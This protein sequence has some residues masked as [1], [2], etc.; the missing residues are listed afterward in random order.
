MI[1]LSVPPLVW[2]AGSGDAE[3]DRRTRRQHRSVNS[4]LFMGPPFKSLG[5][6]DAPPVTVAKWFRAT[7]DGD[8]NHRDR[9]IWPERCM[10]PMRRTGTSFKSSDEY[11]CASRH[12]ALK[13]PVLSA[14]ATSE[15]GPQAA[16]TLCR[17]FADVNAARR[18]DGGDI[19]VREHEHAAR[20]PARPVHPADRRRHLDDD[21]TRQFRHSAGPRPVDSRRR[22][23]SVARLGRCRDPDHLCRAGSGSRTIRRPAA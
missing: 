15:S 9:A 12:D 6:P 5:F 23:A 19:S 3:R 11:Q 14:S 10:R 17:P 13:M 18:R 1:V 2:P 16:A 21:G 7:L 8:N 4:R 20:A 22:R